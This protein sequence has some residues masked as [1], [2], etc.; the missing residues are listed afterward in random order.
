MKIRLSGCKSVW[1]PD[2][3]KEVSRDEIFEVSDS[4]GESLLAQGDR[5]ELVLENKKEGK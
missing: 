4:I 3:K 2:A 1:I 5:F